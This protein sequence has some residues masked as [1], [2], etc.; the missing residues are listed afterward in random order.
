[1]LDVVTEKP[2]S[3]QDSASDD[4]KFDSDSE[5]MMIKFKILLLSF[6]GRYRHIV[7]RNGHL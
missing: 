4:E 3:L 5:M 2:G 7:R 1:M 6:V